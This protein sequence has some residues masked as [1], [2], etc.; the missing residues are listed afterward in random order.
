[1][2]RRKSVGFKRD[3]GVDSLYG[4]ELIQKFINVVMSRGKKNV[5]RNIV[6]EA[7]EALT[8][9][10]GGEKERGLELF[11]KAF[12]EVVPTVEVRPRRVGGSVYQVPREVPKDRA[13]ALAMRW[14]I[15]AAA[16]RSAKTMGQRLAAELLEASEGRGN[17][18]KKKQDMHRMAESNRAFSHYAW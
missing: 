4:S 7:L 13:K 11:N 5:A 3:I 2:P 16:G 17:A 6:Y 9:K 8:K 12:F 14:L 10:A 18:I 15:S 1:M